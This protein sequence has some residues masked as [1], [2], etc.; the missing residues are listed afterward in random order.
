MTRPTCH[1]SVANAMDITSSA[2]IEIDPIS[3]GR[4]PTRSASH[5]PP[6]PDTVE[7]NEYAATTRPAWTAEAPSSWTR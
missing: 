1:S 6:I 5:P 4:R 2:V 7:S 3:T